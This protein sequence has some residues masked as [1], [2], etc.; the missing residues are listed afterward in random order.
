[1]TNS[2]HGKGNHNSNAPD[3]KPEL[4]LSRFITEPSISPSAMI[5]ADQIDQAD[6]DELTE[7][8]VFIK[9]EER[10]G[11]FLQRDFCPVCSI[12]Q[13]EGLELLPIA[14]ALRKY[15]WLGEKYFSK[16]VPADLNKMTAHIAS[17]AEP[18]G[19]FI[20]VEKGIKVEFPCQAALYMVQPNIAQMI[21]NV[22]ILEEGAELHLITGC[23]SQ[24]EVAKGVHIAISENY[25][26]K[27]AKLTNTMIHSWGPEV[28]VRPNSGAIVE[29]GGMFVSNYISLRPAA[30][31]I[32]DPRTWLIGR[33]ASAK[34]LTIILGSEKSDITTGGE[35]YL[36]AD[37]TSAELAHRAVCTGGRISQRGLLVGN[38]SC[39]AHVDCAGMLLDAGNSGYIESIPGLKAH[40]PEARM[41]HEASIGR[42]APEQVEYLQSRG[43]EEREAISMIIRGFLDADVEGLGP[44]LDARIAEIAELAGHGEE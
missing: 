2:L 33:G 14:E 26:G 25:V 22:V 23:I 16:A 20:R 7:V 8:G 30:D 18:A 27:N 3:D 39:R 10:S 34:Y 32:S 17:L 44:E 9:G 40:H 28:I 38:S 15:D 1:M 19:Y 43:M 29:E 6:A 36:N 12:A 35:V 5:P 37:G 42:I 4:D 11:T 41:S 21:H 13:T 24:H 31:I